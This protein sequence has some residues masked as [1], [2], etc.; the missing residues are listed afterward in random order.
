MEY[1]NLVYQFD[2]ETGIAWLSINRP[3]VKNALNRE[4]RQELRTV[5]DSLNHDYSVKVLIITGAGEDSFVAGADIVEFQNAKPVE[6]EEFASTLGQALTTDI[7]NL[8]MP[9]IAMIN[10]YCFGAGC[11][12]AMACDIRIASDNSKFGQLEINLGLIPGAGGTQRLPHLVGAGRAKEIMF[13]G[14]ILKADEA[15]RIGWI[16]RMVPQAE[17]EEAVTRLAETI[18]SKS[19]LI[20]RILKKTINNGLNTDLQSGLAC[21]KANFALCFDTEDIREGIDAFRNKRKAQFSGK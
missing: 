1:T 19:S 11:E 16:D 8:P 4:T 6:I 13:S 9:V 7:S 2:E 20:Q 18:A 5:V 21:E 17:L 3:E 12:L 10:G 14:R 15:E